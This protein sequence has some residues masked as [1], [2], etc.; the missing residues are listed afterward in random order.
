MCIYNRKLQYTIFVNTPARF[1][2]VQLVQF[3]K[4]FQL[5]CLVSGIELRD[6]PRISEKAQQGKL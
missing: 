5:L 2:L 6:L 1:E 3:K 4:S